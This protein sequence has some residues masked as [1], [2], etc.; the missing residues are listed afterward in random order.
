M[1]NTG[2]PLAGSIAIMN[3]IAR[4]A[5]VIALAAAYTAS[6]QAPSD[7]ARF[8]RSATVVVLDH[9]LSLGRGLDG[10][11]APKGPARNRHGIQ[12]LLAR[13][14]RFRIAGV[15]ARKGKWTVL[16]DGCT[17]TSATAALAVCRDRRRASGGSFEVRGAPGREHPRLDLI[18]GV[19]YVTPK[20][21]CID[22]GTSGESRKS[23]LDPLVGARFRHEFN[24]RW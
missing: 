1:R 7:P 3:C 5:F 17:S 6:A 15:E 14:P 21:A 2:L 11:T 12:L 19:R 24:D 9:S 23:W 18:F 8:C 13:Q 20:R 4:F 10:D 22:A 16:L